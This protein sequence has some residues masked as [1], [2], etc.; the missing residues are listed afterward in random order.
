MSL[1][2]LHPVA[3]VEAFFGARSFAAYCVVPSF[4]TGRGQ[5]LQRCGLSAP[6]NCNAFQGIK[7]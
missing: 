5:G 4:T 1:F 3:L 7:T 6:V 2:T